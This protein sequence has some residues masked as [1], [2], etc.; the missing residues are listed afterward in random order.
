MIIIFIG[1]N[2]IREWQ[3]TNGNE[4]EVIFI[5]QSDSAAS[6]FNKTNMTI[7]YLFEAFG[8]VVY[9]PLEFDGIWPSLVQLRAMNKVYV[10]SKRI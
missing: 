9:T 2:E 3:I 6:T 8:N 4:Q 7:G 5:H 10:L 1:V